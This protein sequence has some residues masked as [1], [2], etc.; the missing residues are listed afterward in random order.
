M[1]LSSR[2]AKPVLELPETMY[3]FDGLLMVILQTKTPYMLVGIVLGTSIEPFN[4]SSIGIE[5][6]VLNSLDA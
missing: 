3:F 2:T 1:A 5:A 4:A 6:N